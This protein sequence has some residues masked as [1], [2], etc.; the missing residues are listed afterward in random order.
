VAQLQRIGRPVHPAWAGLTITPR[1][2]E[3]AQRAWSG[4]SD[5]PRAAMLLGDLAETTFATREGLERLIE[6]AIASPARRENLSRG[7]AGRVR[8]HYSTQKAAEGI[9]GLVRGALAE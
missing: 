2:L 3:T 8:E 7:I 1:M 4:M 6:R 5:A 9:L